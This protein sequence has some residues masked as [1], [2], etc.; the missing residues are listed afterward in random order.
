MRSP[1]KIVEGRKNKNLDYGRIP[2][3]FSG[4]NPMLS[5]P[6]TWVQSCRSQGMAKIK[7]MQNMNIKNMQKE[8]GSGRQ[9]R[10]RRGWAGRG[11]R[12]SLWWNKP[13]GSI[14]IERSKKMRRENELSDYIR[15]LKCYCQDR[16]DQ[17]L[18]KSVMC[19]S[20]VNV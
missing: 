8:D 9:W 19:M 4:Q 12:R 6:R 3:Q 7:R 1:T 15:G 16:Y 10:L 13:R 5:L 20:C 18:F 2:L 14:S 11:Y 17:Y